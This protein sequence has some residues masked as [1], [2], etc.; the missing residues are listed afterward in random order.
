M[1]KQSVI[2]NTFVKIKLFFSGEMPQINTE[3]VEIS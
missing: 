1:K 2:Q 3:N